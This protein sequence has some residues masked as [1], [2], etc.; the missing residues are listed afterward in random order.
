M[1]MLN[2]YVFICTYMYNVRIEIHICVFLCVCKDTFMY[3]CVH[4][5]VDIYFKVNDYYIALTFLSKAI[6]WLDIC[7]CVCICKGRYIF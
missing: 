2:M 7:I 1:C 4:M 6:L 5:R 3:V